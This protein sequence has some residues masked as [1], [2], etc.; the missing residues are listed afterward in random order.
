MSFAREASRAIRSTLVLWVISAIIYPFAMI[1]FGQVVF[2]FQANGS[3]LTNNTG[4]VVGSALIGQPF[5]SD[6]YFNSRPS[7]TS[8]STA[9][10]KKDDAGVLKTGVSGASNLAPSNSALLE[11]IKGKDDP[12]PSKRVEGDFNRLKTA[13]IQPT[14]DLVYTSG[15]SLDPHITPEAAIAQ[16]ARVAKA[17][18]VQPTQ[19]ETLIAQNTDGR[20]LGIFGEPGVNVLKLNLALD[21]IKA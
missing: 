2:P 16:I 21:Q 3:L 7:T 4:Q 14:A 13:G 17:R 11:R 12:D 9:D 6:R 5:S 19:L 8:Y 18:G 1:A 15:S 20:F 10:P